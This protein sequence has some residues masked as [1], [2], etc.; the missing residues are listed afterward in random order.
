MKNTLA[1]AIA[2]TAALGLVGCS[3][4]E[5]PPETVQTEPATEQ[6]TAESMEGQQ[7]ANEAD[8]PGVPEIEGARNMKE[9]VSM[10]AF[11]DDAMFSTGQGL[12]ISYVEETQLSEFGASEC[13]TG[14]PVSV[15]KVTAKNET[16]SMWKPYEDLILAA[17]YEDADSGEVMDAPSV[18]DGEDSKELDAGMSLPSLMNGKS[19]SSLVGFCHPGGSA[20]SVSVFGSFYDEDYNPAGDAI[21]VSAESD[22]L[23]S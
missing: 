23:G 12:K 11:G 16:G 5:A 1:I 3:T 10:F 15:F 13:S 20:D 2:G 22:A 19:G 9:G 18:F 17:S 14:D 4:A 6:P 8:M 7:T 21:W